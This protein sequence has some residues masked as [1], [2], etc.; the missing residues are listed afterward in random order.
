[1]SR[2]FFQ[3]VLTGL[4]VTADGAL[5]LR[6]LG[7]LLLLKVWLIGATQAAPLEAPLQGSTRQAL[8]CVTEDVVLQPLQRV[9]SCRRATAP[10]RCSHRSVSFAEGL[11]AGAGTAPLGVKSPPSSPCNAAQRGVVLELLKQVTSRLRAIVQYPPAHGIGKEHSGQT[12]PPAPASSLSAATKDGGAWQG[13]PLV[14]PETLLHLGQGQGQGGSSISRRTSPEPASVAEQ[15]LDTNAEAGAHGA[16]GERAE[17]GAGEGARDASRERTRRGDV[18]GVQL[19]VGEGSAEV[20]LVR[21]ALRGGASTRLIPAG[22][23][24]KHLTLLDAPRAFCLRKLART[25]RGCTAQLSP[26]CAMGDPD[27]LTCPAAQI[28]RGEH[29]GTE[30]SRGVQ[31]GR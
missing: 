11:T 27:F 20:D 4:T 14:H 21:W 1:M 30:G 6:A 19:R 17:A 26:P 28:L 24:V 12:A 3:E 10:S 8:P 13:R 25:L 31:G 5:N 9:S 7:S 22:R 15:E 23:T 16:A 29:R 18:Q 2:A